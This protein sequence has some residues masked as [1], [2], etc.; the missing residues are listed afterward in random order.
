MTSQKIASPK[1][2][3]PAVDGEAHEK[4]YKGFVSFVEISTLVVLCWVISLAI[5]GVK[6]AWGTAVLGVIV[7]AVAGAVG[8]FNP[9]V[10]IRA[11]AIIAFALALLLLFY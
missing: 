3:S 9:S 7:S 11:P 8:A 2:F 10:G 1:S 4:T 5:G 6:E